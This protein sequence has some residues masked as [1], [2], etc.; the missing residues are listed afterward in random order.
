VT[1]R[2]L[3]VDDHAD[4]RAAA[5]DLLAL[6][7]YAV[8]GEAGCADS[9]V[10]AAE[11]LQPDAVML[12]VQLRDRNGFEVARALRGV[13]PGAAVLLVSTG[14]FGDDEDLVRSVGA[15]GFVPKSQLLSADLTAYWPPPSG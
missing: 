12:D 15:A 2:V 6:R 13:C 11:R 8:I 7:G 1:T 5:R 3:I 9:G 4:F 14:D 10:A